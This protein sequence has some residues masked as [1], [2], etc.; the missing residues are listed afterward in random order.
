MVE[1]LRRSDP[2]N[3]EVETLSAISRALFINYYKSTNQIPRFRAEA[4]T[5]ESLLQKRLKSGTGVSNVNLFLLGGLLGYRGLVDFLAEGK[6]LSAFSLGLRGLEHL[7]PTVSREPVIEDSYFGLALFHYY[8]GQFGRQLSWLKSA[9]DDEVKAY[10]YIERPIS[11]GFFLKYEAAFRAINFRVWDKKWDG[12]EVHLRDMMRQFPGNSY[13]SFLILEYFYLKSDWPRLLEE[14]DRCLSILDL[15]PASG[16]SAYFEA[17]VARTLALTRLG[18]LAE[19]DALALECERSIPKL[20]NWSGNDYLADILK[21]TKKEIG[22]LKKGPSD[23][24]VPPGS[25]GNR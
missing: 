4:R 2:G 12:L 6:L 15:E 3:A 22:D 11:N 24:S 14:T 21:K 23:R 25:P 19:A 18:R 10:G 5:A 17:K 7:K 9:M 16:R 13:L 20:E 8:R 1:D